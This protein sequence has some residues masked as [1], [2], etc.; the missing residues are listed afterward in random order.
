MIRLGDLIRR[1]H[2]RKYLLHVLIISFV[3]LLASTAQVASY[4]GE[5]EFYKEKVRENPD[6]AEAHFGLGY[7]YG[8]AANWREAIASFKQAIKLDPDNDAMGALAHFGLCSAYFNLGMYKEA[9]ES[10]K[11]AIR[12]DPD[13]RGAHAGLGIAYGSLG[14]HKESIEPFK[15]AIRIDPDNVAAHTALGIAYYSLGDKSSALEQY[16]ILKK[17]DAEM[18]DLLFNLI[19]K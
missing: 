4:A 14:M 11:Q 1:I 5:M 9:I 7:A 17:L 12:I 10:G 8:D 18:A 15:Q 16:K 19:Y 3:F 6:D 2:M 13:Y